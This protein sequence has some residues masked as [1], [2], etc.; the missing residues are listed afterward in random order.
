MAVISLLSR[1]CRAWKDFF[2]QNVKSR[3]QIDRCRYI[4]KVDASR[5][6]SESCGRYRSSG[7]TSSFSNESFS[8]L[9]DIIDSTSWDCEL[10]DDSIEGGRCESAK[11]AT[12][13]ERSRAI[14]DFAAPPVVN[15]LPP[16]AASLTSE[17]SNLLKSR[18][19]TSKNWLIN[20][21]LS[22][23]LVG[24]ESFPCGG[25]SLGLGKS[26]LPISSRDIEE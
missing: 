4:L 1:V 6:R 16:S 9:C 17:V 7:G 8:G 11:S 20:C 2:I 12:R 22:G 21:V 10:S 19:P 24:P 13:F 18:R 15:R 3:R 5:S 26:G 23:D 25:D 14:V